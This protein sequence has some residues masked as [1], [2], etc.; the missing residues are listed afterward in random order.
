MGRLQLFLTTTLLLV[1]TGTI[2]SFNEQYAFTINYF[3]NFDE[4]HLFAPTDSE[5]NK[6]HSSDRKSSE[7]SKSEVLFMIGG[8]LEPSKANVQLKEIYFPRSTNI[9]N[10]R[11]V[12]REAAHVPI[13]KSE[14]QQLRYCGT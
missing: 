4:S 14:L 7:L 12:F 10:S 1:S 11:N 2:G 5:R 3:T 13:D 9:R 8:T 6:Q